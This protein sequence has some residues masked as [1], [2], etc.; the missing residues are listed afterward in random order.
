[1]YCIIDVDYFR[2]NF[3]QVVTMT[4]LSYFLICESLLMGLVVFLA[5]RQRGG[6]E[7]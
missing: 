6:K 5:T 3:A 7:P 1:M 4:P 2:A